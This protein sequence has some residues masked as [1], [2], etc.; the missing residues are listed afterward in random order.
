MIAIARSRGTQATK[1]VL[2]LSL[3]LSFG[4]ALL[5]PGAHA[6]TAAPGTEGVNVKRSA[7]L[8]D[9]PG[10]GSRTLATLPAQ[11]SLTR[12]PERQG[13]WVRVRTAQGETGWVHLFDLGTE[14]SA[15]SGSGSNAA[16]GALRGISNFFNKGSAQQSPT[17]FTPTSTLGIRGLGAQDIANAQPNPA[18]VAR[19]ESLRLDAAQAQ[20][21]G[22]DAALRV[23]AVEP[24]PAPPAPR[25]APAQT[26]PVDMQNGG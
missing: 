10:E 15:N 20:K 19:A 6:Q 26:S 1:A 3:C 23:Q 25:S 7:T 14:G 17:A 8:R 22:A 2:C 4:L 24:L 16:A 11:T 12:L 21:F 5:G 13:P 9:A 18:A